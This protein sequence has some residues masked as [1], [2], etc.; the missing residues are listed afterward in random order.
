MGGYYSTLESGPQT[1]PDPT[2]TQT[3]TVL[4][5]STTSGRANDLASAAMAPNL[6]PAAQAPIVGPPMVSQAPPSQSDLDAYQQS[7]QRAQQRGYLQDAIQ[8]END[9]LNSM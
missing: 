6:Q 9:A 8:R 7:Q 3:S 5:S 1:Q 2:Q 4:D